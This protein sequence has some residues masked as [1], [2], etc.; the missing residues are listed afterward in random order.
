MRSF[1]RS[2][3]SAIVAVVTLSVGVGAN[4]AIFSVLFAVVLRELPYKD[5]GRLAVLWTHG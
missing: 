3:L 1:R 4:A 2:P 5:V